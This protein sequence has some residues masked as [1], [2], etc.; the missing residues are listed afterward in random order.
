LLFHLVFVFA[1]SQLSHGGHSH[2]EPRSEASTTLRPVVT[3]R[4]RWR[5]LAL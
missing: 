1:V 5:G 2:E 3:A 4:S